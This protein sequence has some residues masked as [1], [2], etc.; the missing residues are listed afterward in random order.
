M[1][2]QDARALTDSRRLERAFARVDGRRLAYVRRGEGAPPVV[3]LSGASMGLDSWFKVFPAIAATTTALMYDRP[4]V[5]GSEP[6]D[7]PQ[8]GDVIVRSL[9]DL[10]VQSAT[11][12][13]YVLVGHSLGGLFVELFAR[14]HPDEVAGVV[15]VDAATTEEAEHPP[16]RGPA[17]RIIDGISGLVDRARSRSRLSDVD[18]VAATAAQI[19][20]SAPFPPIP[21]VVIAGGHRMRMVPQ[22]AFDAHL[23]AQRR[24]VSISPLGSLVIAGRSGHFPHLTEPDVVIDA[25][26]SVVRI[27]RQRHENDMGRP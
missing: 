27:V 21:A 11:P 13:P 9:R 25:I 22:A 2:R 26:R 10:L 24:R 18:G 4:G 16:P 6:P 23:D 19:R 8:T 14:R 12:P 15:L 1:H 20:A 3:F 5:G 7:V 17:M